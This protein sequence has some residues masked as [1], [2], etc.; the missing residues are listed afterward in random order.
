MSENCKSKTLKNMHK[1]ANILDFNVFS[2]QKSELLIKIKNHLFSKKEPLII[3]TPNAEQLVQAKQNPNF[4]RYLKQANILIPDGISLVWASRLLAEAGQSEPIIERIAGVDL[5]K[6][7]IELT[8][9]LGLKVLVIGG[10]GYE[11][12]V[13]QAKKV[14]NYW[15]LAGNIFW[16]AGYQNVSQAQKNEIA[17]LRQV[18]KELRPEV[19]LVAFGAP[20]Q[21][22]WIIEQLSLLTA[23]EVKLVMAVGGAFDMLLGKIKRAP[24][25]LQHL[26]LEWLFRLIQEP[27]RW[28]RQ[29][30]LIKFV[31][32]VIKQKKIA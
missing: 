25:W 26:G 31:R 20:A 3:F 23:S 30:R 4:N 29:L 12:V 24:A 17:Q 15:Q 10:Q 6:D 9:E 32:L 16:T 19:V 22:K 14:K 5:V 13:P 11:Q 7:L 1:T 2:R 21:E 28:R 8:Q 18:I 27:W